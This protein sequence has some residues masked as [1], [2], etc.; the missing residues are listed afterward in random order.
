MGSNSKLAHGVH[1]KRGSICN[2]YCGACDGRMHHNQCQITILLAHDLLSS[3]AYPMMTHPL[4]LASIKTLA[5]RQLPTSMCICMTL[6]VNY[7]R[8]FQKYIIF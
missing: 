8:A 1:V 4:P 5:D 2:S 3:L 6:S 7:T